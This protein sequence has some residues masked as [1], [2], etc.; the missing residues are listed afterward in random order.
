MKLFEKVIDL[1]QRDWK[2]PEAR[3]EFARAQNRL[4]LPL[5]NRHIVALEEYIRYRR[6]EAL[7]EA[8]NL[9]AEARHPITV[10]RFNRET[11]DQLNQVI[12]DNGRAVITFLPE[13]CDAC[14]EHLAGLFTFASRNPRI[15]FYVVAIDRRTEPELVQRDL[16][17][18]QAPYWQIISESSILF[19]HDRDRLL[20]NHF[21]LHGE[22][23]TPCRLHGPCF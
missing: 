21:A 16:N 10:R 2:Y 20:L 9:L 17:K 19:Y 7:Q 3:I 18:W 13:L 6:G 14:P 15:D 23:H 5:G 1:D 12:H 8:R 11:A 22:G 4:A